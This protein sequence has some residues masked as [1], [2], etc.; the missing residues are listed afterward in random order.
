MY[1]LLRIHSDQN[2]YVRKSQLIRCV[3]MRAQEG[4]WRLRSAPEHLPGMVLRLAAYAEFGEPSAAR[5][6]RSRH[7]VGNVDRRERHHAC[8]A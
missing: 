1:R 7:K 6:E 5:L 4:L 8:G 3:L 2:G